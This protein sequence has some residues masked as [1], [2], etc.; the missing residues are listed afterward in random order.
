RGR[1]RGER[2]RRGKKRE[3]EEGGEG[4]GEGEE[5]RSARE[6]EKVDSGYRSMMS[7]QSSL[8]MVPV[9]T[10]GAEAQKREYLPKR[11]TGE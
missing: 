9:E 8:V 4:R 1:E 6:G 10:F 5:G 7:V 11:A 3:K 2:G